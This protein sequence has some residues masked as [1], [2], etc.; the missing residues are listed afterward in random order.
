MGNDFRHRLLATRLAF[1]EGRGSGLQS[2]VSDRGLSKCCPRAGTPKRPSDESRLK[3]KPDESS[4]VR[5]QPKCRAVFCILIDASR[6]NRYKEQNGNDAH[7]RLAS[8]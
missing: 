1:K 4:R 6:E 2:I 3:E 5:L 7:V 8:I